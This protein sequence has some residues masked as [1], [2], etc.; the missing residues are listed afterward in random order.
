MQARPRLD[1]YVLRLGD[2][3]AFIRI[4]AMGAPNRIHLARESLADSGHLEGPEATQK[5]RG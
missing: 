3:F 5:V 4:I 1:V 2:I